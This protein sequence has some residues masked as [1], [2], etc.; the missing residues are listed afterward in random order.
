MINTHVPDPLEESSPTHSGIPSSCDTSEPSTPRMDSLMYVSDSLDP[1]FPPGVACH[2]EFPMLSEPS[3]QEV[4]VQ[5]HGGSFQHSETAGNEYNP[6]TTIKEHQP[7]AEARGGAIKLAGR[8]QSDCLSADIDKSMHDIFESGMTTSSSVTANTHPT[9]EEQSSIESHPTTS[10]S[11][12]HL[13]LELLLAKS[14]SNTG[15]ESREGTS[16]LCQSSGSSLWGPGSRS[17]KLYAENSQPRQTV[18]QPVSSPTGTMSSSSDFYCD[19]PVQELSWRNPS[20]ATMCPCSPVTPPPQ[21]SSPCP[22]PF[23][24]CGSS[25]VKRPI[26]KPKT[27]AKPVASRFCHICSRMPRRGQGSAVCRNMNQGLCRKIVCERCIVEQGWDYNAVTENPEAWLCPH[28]AG[29]CP[30]RSQCHIYNRINARRKRVTEESTFPFDVQAQCSSSNDAY[31]A[32][33]ELLNPFGFLLEPSLLP[34]PR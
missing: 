2:D 14:G 29:I 10:K 9:A 11:Y 27:Y 34:Q 23:Q 28:C 7:Q 32:T 19:M 17:T 3:K 20:S 18:P 26:R 6:G 31:N 33:K 13:D 25:I 4:Q 15:Q 5:A 12:H 30:A 8:V 16:S 24:K 1:F 22:T 21:N